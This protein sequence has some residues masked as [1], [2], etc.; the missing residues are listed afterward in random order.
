M[1]LAW[2]SV[3]LAVI[4][5]GSIVASGCSD[6]VP[7]PAQGAVTYRMYKAGTQ[8][9]Q[10]PPHTSNAPS[11]PAG[12]GTNVTGTNKG[13]EAVDGDNGAKVKCKV[14]AAGAA[15]DVNATIQVGT[16]SFAMNTTI[17]DQQEGVDGTVDVND[18]QTQASY[19]Q[20]VTYAKPP[21]PPCKFSVKP[22]SGEGYGAASGRIWGK[23]TCDQAMDTQNPGSS[24]SI[25]GTF[26]F[27]NCD[28]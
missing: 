28:Q 2:N 4:A 10:I 20:P 25:E 24:C 19:L 16:V 27:E 23:F 21:T 13:N 22:A 9:C 3:A 17:A 1:S 5:A 6:P 7:P 8:N 14:A 11:A 15:F 18:N 12:T 26:V